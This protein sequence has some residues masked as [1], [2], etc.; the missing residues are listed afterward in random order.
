MVS[1]GNVGGATP[2]PIP[3]T[4]VKPSRADGTAGVTLWESRTPGRSW[5]TPRAALLLFSEHASHGARAFTSIRAEGGARYERSARSLTQG[6]E[7]QA[8]RGTRALT[9]RSG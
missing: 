6:A 7:A 4:E 9:C 3:N 8:S 5:L 1:G 2:V